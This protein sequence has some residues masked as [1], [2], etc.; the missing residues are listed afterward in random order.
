MKKRYYLSALSALPLLLIF[1]FIYFLLHQ[2]VEI[3][4]GINA[5]YVAFFGLINLIG[6]RLIYRPVDRLLKSGEVAENSNRAI[7]KLAGRTSLWILAIGV[8]YVILTLIML[9]MS[10]EEMGGDSQAFEIEKIPAIM[11]IKFIPSLLYVHAV[12]PAVIGY[13]LVSDF[14][15]DLKTEAFRRFQMV[16][17]AREN[18]IAWKLIIVFILLVFYP[19]TLVILDLHS[20]VTAPEQYKQFSN[21]NPLETVLV[22]RFVVLTGTILSVILITRSFTRPIHSLLREIHKVGAGDFTT[23]AAITTGDEIGVLTGE[24][25]KMVQGLQEREMIRDTFGKYVTDDVANVI[26]NKEINLEGET[27]ECTIL[28]TDIKGYTTISE[29]LEPA[30]IVHLLNEYF[31]EVVGIIERHKGVVNKFIGD[32]VLAVFNVPVDNPNHARD[33]VLAAQEIRDLTRERKFD[34]DQKLETR[35][36]VNTGLVVAGNL[37]SSQRLEY[38]V[39]GDEVNIAARLEQLNKSFDSD[40]LVG[41]KT[42]ELAAAA[43]LDFHYKGRVRL[44]GKERPIRVFEVV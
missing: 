18:R 26:L 4:M 38:T 31:T 5:V 15:M 40:I 24:F 16:F 43:G 36:G 37:G 2:S 12:F 33:A 9:A 17:Q 30:E 3:W 13:F 10:P 32:A 8:V 20:V 23:Q 25:N 21:V 7:D 11:L 41:E 28:A 27:R 34:R 39:I 29:G 44:K 1:G 19:A 42:K 6:A 35:V 14:S 22:D